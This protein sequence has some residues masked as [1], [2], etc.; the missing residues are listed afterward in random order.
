VA[1]GKP[2]QGTDVRK[3]FEFM[4]MHPFAGERVD[5]DFHLAIGDAVKEPSRTPW[6]LSAPVSRRAL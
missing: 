6:L 4:K 1:G 5:F 2:F 3:G